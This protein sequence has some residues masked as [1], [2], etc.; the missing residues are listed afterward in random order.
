M[1]L[2]DRFILTI[3]S[4]ALILLSLIVIA[5]AANW[6]PYET[7]QYVLEGMYI[8]HGIPYIIVSLVFLLIS[9]RFF[10]SSITM[11]KP[12]SEAG[13]RQRGEHGEVIISLDT[14]RAIAERA[15]RKIRGVRGLKTTIRATEQGNMIVLRISVDG[16]EPLPEMTEKLQESVKMQVEHIA[17]IEIAEVAVVISEVAG[18]DNPSARPRRVE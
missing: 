16:E 1:N 14:I 11:K 3:Y 9:L 4:F 6:I 12:R 17:G 15:A 8:Q 5:M 18:A 2:F 10:V 13:I 7:A